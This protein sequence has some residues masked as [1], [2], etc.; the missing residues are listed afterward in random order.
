M[1]VKALAKTTTFKFLLASIASKAA[2]L[3]G[4][5]CAESKLTGPI[6]AQLC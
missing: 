2:R 3:T 5:V 4:V 6:M 1:P